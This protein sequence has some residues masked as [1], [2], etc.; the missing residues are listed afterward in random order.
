MLSQRIVLA[1]LFF[2]F[3]ILTAVCLKW[4]LTSF[5]DQNDHDC[6]MSF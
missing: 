1:I 6:N 2:I 4:M 3:L 5:S